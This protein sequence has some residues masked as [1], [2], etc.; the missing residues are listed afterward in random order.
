MFFRELPDGTYSYPIPKDKKKK[1][2]IKDCYVKGVR[3]KFKLL[4]GDGVSDSEFF[5]RA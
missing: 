5:G 2:E 3:K 4:P 1:D